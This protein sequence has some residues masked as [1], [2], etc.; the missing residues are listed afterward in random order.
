MSYSNPEHHPRSARRPA[1]PVVLQ[2]ASSVQADTVLH[3]MREQAALRAKLVQTQAALLTLL[4]MPVK[5]CQLQDRMQFTPEG[6]AILAQARAAL[7]D[8][9]QF[10]PEGWAILAQALE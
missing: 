6:R 1:P 10:T 5:G 9:V 2:D 3:L 8:R 4:S 7:E